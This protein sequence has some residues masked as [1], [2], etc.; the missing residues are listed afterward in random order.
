MYTSSLGFR[1]CRISKIR[2]PL[3]GLDKRCRGLYSQG[4]RISNFVET[5]KVESF[6]RVGSA[7]KDHLAYLGTL[8]VQGL[9]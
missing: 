4:L 9:G 2:G 1:V 7:E 6:K 3:I 8:S 5:F